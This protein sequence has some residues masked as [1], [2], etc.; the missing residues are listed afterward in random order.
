MV[1]RHSQQIKATNKSKQI[2]MKKKEQAWINLRSNDSDNR[3][4]LLI[5]LKRKQKRNAIRIHSVKSFLK[6]L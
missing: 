1:L 3:R 6:Q 2:A 5:S 4:K